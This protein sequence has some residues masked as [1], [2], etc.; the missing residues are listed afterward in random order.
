VGR[1]SDYLT[2]LRLNLSLLNAATS[3]EEW[4]AL[5]DDFA[6]WLEDERTILT[7]RAEH[8]EECAAA[9]LA[10]A[11]AAEQRAEVAEKALE[12]MA[13]E[14]WDAHQSASVTVREAIAAYIEQAKDAVWS[15][16]GANFK[17]GED[18]PC[19]PS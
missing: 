2:T 15:G 14:H 6:K 5:R 17:A 3:S 13:D 10:R 1:V 12:L 16:R 19:P 18:N 4:Y 9:M 8:A 7:A 11:E